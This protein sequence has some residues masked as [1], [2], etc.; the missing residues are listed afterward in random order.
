M[1]SDL[2]AYQLALEAE[3]KIV[4]QYRE[5][6]DKVGDPALKRSLLRVLALD[7]QELEELERLHDFV[8]APTDAL[9]WGEFSNLDEY[10]NF[11]RYTDLRQGELEDP[12]IPEPV[13]H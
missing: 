5:V 10:H 4:G 6:L 2:E 3:R 11:G 1:T 8:N 7:K 12:V 9:E 13:K